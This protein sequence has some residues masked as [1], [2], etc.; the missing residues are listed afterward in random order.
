M[1]LI[2]EEGVFTV[3]DSDMDEVLGS[4]DSEEAARYF[5]NENGGIL[6]T[7]LTR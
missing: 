1:I 4:F 6:V 3:L 5:I 7:D 2:C